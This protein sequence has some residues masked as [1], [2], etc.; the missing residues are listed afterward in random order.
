MSLATAP[1][2]RLAELGIELPPPAPVAGNYLA[3]KRDGHLVFVSG[4]GPIRHEH[5][6]PARATPSRT[7]PSADAVPFIIQGKVG[8]DLT[9]DAAREAARVTGLSAVALRV[10]GSCR[11]CAVGTGV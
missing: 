9:V 5:G 1:E 10:V 3:A 11:W 2:K 4:H 8:A 6:A 7:T